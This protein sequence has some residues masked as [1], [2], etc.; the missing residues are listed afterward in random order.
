MSIKTNKYSLKLRKIL[1][2]SP[3]FD[4]NQSVKK[5]RKKIEQLELVF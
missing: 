4:K 3:I 2:I 1:H 5:K